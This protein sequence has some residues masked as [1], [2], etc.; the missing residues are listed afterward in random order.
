MNPDHDRRRNLSAQAVL[1]LGPLRE[2]PG[3]AK[4]EGKQSLH[5]TKTGGMPLDLVRRDVDLAGAQKVTV[6]AWV[7]AEAAGNAFLK[8]F[9]YDA[10]GATVS[11]DVDIVQLRGDREGGRVEKTWQL[12][13]KAE[14]G[15]VMLVMVMDGEVWLDDVQ[16]K[17]D[18]RD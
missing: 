4:G 5:L 2:A 14:T 12:D 15:A 3:N 16:V 1:P 13:G 17:V 7:A 11:T 6:S 9:A 18:T 10:S 8:F